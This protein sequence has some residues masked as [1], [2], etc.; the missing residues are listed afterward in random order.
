MPAG[1]RLRQPP[2]GA[3]DGEG[4]GES[5]QSFERKFDSVERAARGKA[6]VN[7][8]L[9]VP[10]MG[11]AFHPVAHVNIAPREAAPPAGQSVRQTKQFVRPANILPPEAVPWHGI[12]WMPGGRDS[13]AA[14]KAREL[15]TAHG[16]RPA[17]LAAPL[18][19]L[20]WRHAETEPEGGGD[21]PGPLDDPEHDT[22]PLERPLR[23]SGST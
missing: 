5:W 22:L 23:I 19:V 8:P 4:W 10:N 7:W 11:G 18:A 9:A 20:A 21:I 13:A 14:G 17:R 16:C 2:N 15:I 12:G 3:S 1:R 6:A